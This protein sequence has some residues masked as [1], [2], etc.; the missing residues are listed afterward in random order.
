MGAGAFAMVEAVMTGTGKRTDVYQAL[1]SAVIA[2]RKHLRWNQARLI[3]RFPFSKPIITSVEKGE[4]VPGRPAE[5]YRALEETLAWP[6]FA[7]DV[8]LDGG[9]P[10]PVD[11]PRPV[12]P[13]G[14]GVTPLADSPE[15]V[16]AE[17]G[18]LV[19]E[20]RDL[21]KARAVRDAEFDERLARL[22]RAAGLE[23]PAS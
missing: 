8:I 1:A 19:S 10:P 17:M 22:E 11:L 9:D 18:R 20:V 7:V 4:V 5:V 15:N 3:K 13:P 2:R 12:D 16:R 6:E 23:P 14:A 21:L